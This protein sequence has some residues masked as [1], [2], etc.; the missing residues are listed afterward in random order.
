MPKSTEIWIG[1]KVESWGRYCD[2]LR[3]IRLEKAFFHFGDRGRAVW[4]FGALNNGGRGEEKLLVRL[5]VFFLIPSWCHLLVTSGVYSEKPE[6][7]AK[8]LH[9]DG[10]RQLKRTVQNETSRV[11]CRLKSLSLLFRSEQF[12]S[13][14]LLHVELGTSHMVI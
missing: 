3:T 5:K 7:S 6:R 14:D 8:Y 1:V 9:S 12:Q 2:A 11:D 4:S 10:T 13:D